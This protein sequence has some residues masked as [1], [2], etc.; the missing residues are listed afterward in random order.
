MYCTVLYLV[1]QVSKQSIILVRLVRSE[2]RLDRMHRRHPP[3]DTRPARMSWPTLLADIGPG[4]CATN[5]ESRRTALVSWTVSMTRPGDLRGWLEST[6]LAYATGI[7]T[8]VVLIGPL[9][10]GVHAS[11]SWQV[12][13]SDARTAG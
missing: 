12:P 4:A 7:D 1:I 9:M 5:V 2:D 3:L 11:L 6:S 13:G 10:A 8:K